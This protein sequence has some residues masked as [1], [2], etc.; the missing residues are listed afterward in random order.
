MHEGHRKRLRE[1]FLKNGL[2]NFQ[3]HNVLEL[4]LF[5]TIPRS[6]TNETAHRLIER[7]GSLSAV[8]EAPVEELMQVQGVGERT[9]SFLHLIPEITR[10]YL[11]DKQENIK[12]LDTPEKAAAYLL[13]YFVGKTKENVV[14]LCLDNKCAVKNCCIVAEGSV[15]MGEINRRNLV[16]IVIRSNASSVVIAH[17]HPNGVPAPSKE[18]VE[19]TLTL[20]SL[21]NSIDVKLTD[22]II[23]AGSDWCSMASS[24]KFAPVF[25]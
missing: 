2:D 18:D 4:L 25:Q 13:P 11:K 15:N 6:D 7:F 22:H 21:F 9:A 5:Y 8:L 12:I 17:N 10:V 16:E 19:I 14:L 24:A 20:A 1:N 3:S 23:V